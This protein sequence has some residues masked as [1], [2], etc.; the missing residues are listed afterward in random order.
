MAR[1]VM[2]FIFPVFVLFPTTQIRVY[3]FLHG[4]LKRPDEITIV[5]RVIS[6]R[7]AGI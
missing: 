5:Y 1:F 7:V 2:I 6:K 3:A 4:W